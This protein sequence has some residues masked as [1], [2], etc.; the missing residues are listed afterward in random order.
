MPAIPLFRY[1]L[2]RIAE[3]VDDFSVSW[4]RPFLSIVLRI[5]ELEVLPKALSQHVP[6]SV[7]VSIRPIGSKLNLHPIFWLVD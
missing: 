7:C 2:D 4:C 3:W 6:V 1:K 5:D